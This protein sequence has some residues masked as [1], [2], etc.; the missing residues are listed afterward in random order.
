MKNLIIPV[1]KDLNSTI[2]L[3][4]NFPFIVSHDDLSE[5]VGGFVNWH[6]QSALEI[7]VVLEGSINVSVL[8]R[9]ETMVVG[10]G[11][12]IL[13]ERLHTLKP[14]KDHK[15]AKYFTLIFEPHL[16]TGYKGSF[17]E[18]HYYLPALSRKETFFKFGVQEDWTKPVF[19]QMKWIYERFPN[20]TPEF[21]LAVQRIIQDIWIILW[22]NLMSMQREGV[23]TQHDT[24]ILDM[25][26]YLHNNY[27]S[28]FSLTDMAISSNVSRGECCRFFKKMMH[29]T[30][31]SYLMEYRISKAVGFLETTNLSIS[32]ISETVGFSSISYFIDSF[33]KKTKY[34]PLTYK[35]MLRKVQL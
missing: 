11:F 29:M 28:K 31:S 21:Q 24:R 4:T 2:K 27:S 14:N 18:Q 5:Y 6:K 25:I 15:V 3:N 12:L 7:A 10:D 8:E 20:D 16:L 33:K 17:F 1:D 19:D 35:K 26:E 22:H 23:S 34:S 13:P 9:E 32:E 30:I